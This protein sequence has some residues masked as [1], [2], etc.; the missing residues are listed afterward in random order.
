MPD[1]WN[2]AIYRERAAAWRDKATTLPEGSREREVCQE[3]AQGMTIWPTSSSSLRNADRAS[4]T[5]TG[6]VA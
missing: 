3:I 1:A 6:L 5:R 4:H 2:A